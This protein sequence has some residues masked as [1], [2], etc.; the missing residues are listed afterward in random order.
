[1]SLVQT[2][3]SHGEQN[4]EVLQQDGEIYYQAIRDIAAHSELLVW[5]GESYESHLGI[6][7]VLPTAKK[8]SSKKADHLPVE[9]EWHVAM[10]P[11]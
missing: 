8:T 1:M 2:A 6:P 9:S 4:M 7:T 11:M 10:K 3:R 5:Y